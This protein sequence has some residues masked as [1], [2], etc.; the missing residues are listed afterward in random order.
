MQGNYEHFPMRQQA[1]K[2]YC[3]VSPCGYSDVG[4]D[5]PVSKDSPFQQQYGRELCL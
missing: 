2:S 3:R 4:K 1:G 5:S